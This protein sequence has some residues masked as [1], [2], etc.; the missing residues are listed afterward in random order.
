MKRLFAPVLLSLLMVGCPPCTP[1][2]E[3]NSNNDPPVDP[4]PPVQT[5]CSDPCEDGE[6]VWGPET[7]VRESCTPTTYIR[8]FN[9]DWD[10]DTCVVV[11]NNG[12]SAAWVKIDGDKVVAENQFNQNVTDIAETTYLEAGQHELK[13][14]V[15]SVPGCSIDVEL[16]SCE[17]DANAEM[18]IDTATAWC[19]NK[20]WSVA[21]TMNGGLICVAP[22]HDEYSHCE[23]CAAYNMVVW[24]DGA[25]DP[26]CPNGVCTT[27]AGNVYGGHEPCECGDNLI[28]CESWEMDDCTAAP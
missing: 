24:L 21:T 18:C 5:S 3:G 9:M 14:R 13:V 22:G 26:L 23:G 17:P 28:W 16:R 15:T 25:S 20:G 12:C 19:L 11:T 8:N 4:D 2:Q 27:F 7:F 1:P 6:R 10:G